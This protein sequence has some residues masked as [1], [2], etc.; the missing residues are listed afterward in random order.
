G[1]IESNSGSLGMGISKARGI[2]WAKRH[3]KLG[4]RVFVL[5]G[6]GELQEGQN[7][8][9]LQTTVQQGVTNLTVIVDHNKLQTDRLIS[10]I[11]DLGDLDRKFSA[12]GWYVQRCDGHDLPTL[13]RVF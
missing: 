1:G 7:Y 11:T 8:E 9:A 6:D 13:A 12:F 3:Q 5:I 10:Q 2:A 4:G